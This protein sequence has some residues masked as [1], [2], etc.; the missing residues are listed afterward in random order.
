MKIGLNATCIN[1]RPSGAKQRFIGIYSE[2]VKR[3][4]EVEFVV[5]EPAD[6]RMS[7]WFNGAANVTTKH[8]ELPSEG[9]I[10]KF[11]AGLG[12]WG[13]ALRSEKFD[14]FEGFNQPLIR[15]PTGRT[16]LTIHDIRRMHS[17]WGGLEHL[18]YK[19]ALER[20]LSS[21]DH[22]ITVSESMKN[23]IHGFFPDIP[24]SVIYNGLNAADFDAVTDEQMEVVRRKY[25]FA[26]GF[27]LAVGHFERRKNYLRLIDAMAL[28]RDRG[29]A[30]SLVIVG[31]DSGE[32]AAIEERVA[33][34][35]LSGHVKILSGL[36]DLEVRCAYKLCS[37]FVFPSSYEGFGI[38]VLEAMAARRPMVLSNIPVFS[39]ITQDKGV[40]FPYDDVDV[41]AHAMERVLSSSSEQARLIEYGTERVKAFSF[42]TLA[43]Q[44]ARLYGELT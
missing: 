29:R 34:A 2:V 38:P 30:C 10:R 39:E 6:C 18:V 40:F 16:L 36:T 23:E 41:M 14:L 1:D 11:L 33:A 4:P 43:G 37:L 9:R 42:P 8:T 13:P 26:E 17:E 15:A 24:I 31:N 19:V 28:L 22:V 32:R 5:Y 25:G 21:A 7:S 27:V 35:S 3:V 20:A 44:L 12:Y